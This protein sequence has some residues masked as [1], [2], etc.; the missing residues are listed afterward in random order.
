MNNDGVCTGHIDAGFDNGRAQ[1]DIETF[2]IEAFHY[3]FEVTL[4][5]LSVGHRDAR[6]GYELFKPCPAVMNRFNF[7]MQEIRLSTALE[8]AQQG[9]SHG[10]VVFAAHKGLDGESFL[11]RRGNH[12]EVP[13]A[14]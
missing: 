3:L 4:S 7:V 12:R 8:F 13:D 14:F 11:W 10:A 1:Q 6:F 5:H 9:F 2:L